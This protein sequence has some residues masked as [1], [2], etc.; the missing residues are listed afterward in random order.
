MLSPKFHLSFE[1][2][3]TSAWRVI[4]K[5]SSDAGHE[6]TEAEIER[7]RSVVRVV[8]EWLLMS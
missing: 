5:L 1:K 8:Q 2:I 3:L 7:D 4:D 6:R